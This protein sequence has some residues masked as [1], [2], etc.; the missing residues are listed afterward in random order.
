MYFLHP[1]YI[2]YLKKVTGALQKMKANITLMM[3]QKVGL[4]HINQVYDEPKK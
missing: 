1:K 2:V 3:E 4:I